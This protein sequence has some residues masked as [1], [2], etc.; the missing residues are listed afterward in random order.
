MCE[1][2]YA[3]FSPANHFTFLALCKPGGRER[4]AE[5]HDDPICDDPPG[6]DRAAIHQEIVERIAAFMRL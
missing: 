2:A 3:T 4:L 5:E 1:P 6:T